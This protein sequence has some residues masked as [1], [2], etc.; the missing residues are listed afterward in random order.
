MSFFRVT[1]RKKSFVSLRKRVTKFWEAGNV[2]NYNEDVKLFII[3]K[4]DDESTALLS[5]REHYTYI[6]VIF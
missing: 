5:I 4:N 6:I 1:F 2:K 3:I